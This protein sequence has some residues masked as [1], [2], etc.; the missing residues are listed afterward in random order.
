MKRIIAI[1]ISLILILSLAAC[2]SANSS[3]RSGYSGDE[4]RQIDPEAVDYDGGA[5]WGKAVKNNASLESDKSGGNS[6][7]SVLKER[8]QIYYYDLSLRTSSFDDLVEKIRSE[9][10]ALGGFTE[11]MSQDEYGDYRSMTLVVRIPAEKAEDFVESMAGS[12]Q[13]ASRGIRSDDVTLEYV[14][15][16]TRLE[17]LESERQALINMMEQ[18]VDVSDLIMIQSRL[19]S[20]QYEIESYTARRNKIDELSGLSTVTFTIH[21]VEWEEDVP[22][23]GEGFWSKIGSGF[24]NS[25]RSLGSFFRNCFAWIII[26]LPY[27]I[28][29]VILI[30]VILFVGR[31]RRKKRKA[32]KAQPQQPSQTPPDAK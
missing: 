25:L 20:V 7:S 15:V 3:D 16:E 30:L 13:V 18:A 9:T 21:E 29:P 1:L 14:D 8:K 11:S 24:M 32:A 12:A 26:S 5:S 19:S 31:S 23:P 17:N 10:A 27:F 28:L 22:A 4:S 2:G 6:G